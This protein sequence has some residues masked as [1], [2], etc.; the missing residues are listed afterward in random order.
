MDP[1]TAPP[2]DFDGVFGPRPLIPHD[3]N[4]RRASMVPPVNRGLA[5]REK[6]RAAA[7]NAPNPSIVILGDPPEKEEST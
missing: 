4:Q 5:E 1:W 7:I 6:A 3:Y 2:L